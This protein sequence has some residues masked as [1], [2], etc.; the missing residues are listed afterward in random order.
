MSRPAHFSHVRV[1]TFLILAAILVAYP[2]AIFAQDQDINL[3]TYYQYNLGFG[4]GYQSL[5]PLTKFGDY[6]STIFDLSGQFIIPIPKLPV[7]QLMLNAG[8]TRVDIRDDEDPETWDHS[9]IYFTLGGG[10][11]SRFTKTL[12]VGGE[13]GIGISQSRYPNLDPDPD[14]I[15]GAYN[16][17]VAVGGRISLVPSYNF[18]LSAQ[19]ML[20][21]IY[22]FSELKNF[23]GVL[24]G[25]GISVNYRVGEDPDA[26]PDIIR[27]IRFS[28]PKIDPLYAA[29][30]SFYTDNPIGTVTVTNTADRMVTDVDLTF[31]SAGYMDGPTSV[32]KLPEL[33]P[34]ESREINLYAAFNNNVFDIEGK[35]P[36]SGEI[37]VVYTTRNRSV[38]QSQQI[39]YDLWDKYSLTWDDDRKVAAYITPADSALK[40]Y[41]STIRQYTKNEVNGGLSERLQ[42]GIQIFSGLT[43]IGLIYQFD[44]LQSFESVQ[45]NA[46][47]VD[48]VSLPRQTLKNAV[49]DCD[50]LTVLYNSLMTIGGVQT[51]FITTPGHIYSVFNTGVPAKDFRLIH[52]D[53]SMTLPLRGEI[54][55]PVE[56]TI[57]GEGSFMDAW[58]RGAEEWYAYENDQAKRNLYFTAEAQMVYQPV[59]LT[60]T[61]L[62]L[63]YGDPA[64]IISTFNKDKNKIVDEIIESYAADARASENKRDY[65]A[66]GK[67]A[68]DFGSYSRAETAFRKALSI[69]RNFLPSQVN[70]GI[71]YLKQERFVDALQTFHSAEEYLLGRNRENSQN[72][73]LVMINISQT[74]YLLENYDK[75]DE[76]FQKVRETDPDLA[77][78]YNYLSGSDDST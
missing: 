77:E 71:V 64:R 39:T 43:E 65:D 72:H 19:P 20:K 53:K 31:F 56:I 36:L 49:G 32:A 4:G 62:G 18:S 35:T 34:E 11:F 41:T 44:P 14:V 17:I 3:N 59:G 37:K 12:E 52:P 23:N 46:L 75:A 27:D 45:G 28:E 60:E 67:I 51:G 25:I 69:D 74:Y 55:V 5:S 54:W 8:A 21:F 30:Q 70:L 9:H 6:D 33:M 73:L 24:F 7:I 10:Y 57:L 26:A 78:R 2:S 38:E 58:R 68:A 47:V 42:L 13:I 66:L 50:D 76:Y 40:N 16:L 29:L 48:T 61:D 63:Q 15:R 22:S 1:R